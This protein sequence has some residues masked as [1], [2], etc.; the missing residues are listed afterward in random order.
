LIRFDPLRN[1]MR[2]EERQAEG[3]SSQRI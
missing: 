1:E 3:D 2:C